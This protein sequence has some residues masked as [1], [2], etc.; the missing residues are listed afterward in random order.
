MT[1][2]RILPDLQ[3][4]LI[5]E[6][7]RREI[8]GSLTLVGVMHALPVP[9]VPFPIFKMF[10][11]NRWTAG[12][13]QFIETVRFLAP[14][15]ATVLRKSDIRFALRDAAHNATNVTF[16]GQLQLPTQGLYHIE[17]LVD[18]VMKLRYPVPVVLVQ[19]QPESEPPPAPP[20][21]TAPGPDSPVAP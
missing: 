3:C 4:S 18:D 13:G 20:Q 12:V 2:T 14:D 19:Q 6:D 7:I 15:G 17:V 8:T 10:V 1:P 16:L 21:G 11:L 5:C 9:Q